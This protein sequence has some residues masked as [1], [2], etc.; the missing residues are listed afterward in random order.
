MKEA[1]VYFHIPF[2]KKKC[3][4][5][6]FYSVT[7]FSRCPL[8]IERLI[9]HFRFF[10]DSIGKPVIT[11]VFIGG[12]TPNS[13]P[14]IQ[15]ERFL[16][17]VSEHIDCVRIEVTLESNPEYI[18]K[19]FIEMINDSAVNRL[20]VGIQSFQPE[21]LQVL[22]RNT[23][24]EQTMRAAEL[25]AGYFNGAVN[26]DLICEIPGQTAE[27]SLRDIELASDFGI[28]HIS[29]YS[30]TIEE[31]TPFYGVY[32]EKDDISDES[33]YFRGIDMLISKGYQRYEVSN[34]SKPGCECLHNIGYWNIDPYIGV[35]PSAVSTFPVKSGDG[36]VWKRTSYPRSVTEYLH[37]D[38]ED[39]TLHDTFDEI[40]TPEEF[41]FE[42]FLMGLRTA[43]G[44]SK[45]RLFGRFP[46][47][48][49]RGIRNVLGYLGRY[50]IESNDFFR[51]K[52]EYFDRQN[53]IL[54]N[55]F[56]EIARVFDQA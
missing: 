39:E 38:M 29:R 53:I 18:T 36:F 19:D 10:Y 51:L 32:S 46:P 40:L 34:F 17:A 16:S 26:F 28:G 47:E 6:D 31:N 12:G 5:C 30:L 25:A 37:M 44:I 2:C 50:G 1:S 27:R 24:A 33:V 7:D 48:A 56:D 11:S 3:G 55:L 49:H 4:Y 20:S 22:Q 23:T 35:G 42:H 41:L 14:L 9:R 54:R 15:L 8:L 21:D 43:K 45:K 13:I 52:P